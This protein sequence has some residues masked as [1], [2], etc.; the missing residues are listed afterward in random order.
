MPAMEILNSFFPSPH[1]KH[2]KEHPGPGFAK[3]L[4]WLAKRSDYSSA[5][6]TEPHL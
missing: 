2:P 6:Y 1:Q 4:K 3:F 5:V